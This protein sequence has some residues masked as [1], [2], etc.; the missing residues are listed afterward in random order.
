MPDNDISQI[1][2]K[3]VQKAAI[4]LIALGPKDSAAILKHLPDD[5]ADRLTRTIARCDQITQE[6]VEYTLDEYVQ[7]VTSEKLLVRGGIEYAHKLLVEAFGEEVA[8]R[9]IS[10]LSKSLES[11]LAVFDNF[12]KVDP[13]QLAKFIQDE[14]PQTIALILS[15]LD[16]Q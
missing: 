11:D 8:D 10:R 4:L 6:N 15:L 1:R 14:H 2:L 13:Q 7:F 16:P 12:R 3:G 5:D 9:L